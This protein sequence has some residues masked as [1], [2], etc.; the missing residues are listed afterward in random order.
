MA[1]QKKDTTKTTAPVNEVKI[2]KATLDFL[3]ESNKM[4]Q[5]QMKKI[6]EKETPIVSK[7]VYKW[8]RQYRYKLFAS[9]EG[10]KEVL[11]PI[12]SY[13]SVK[14]DPSQDWVYENQFGTATNNQN[15]VLTLQG[16]K[17]VLE[18]WETLGRA[19]YSE[20]QFP[21]F[22]EDVSGQLIK[23]D[24]AL[25]ANVE[26]PAAYIFENEYGEFRI[27]PKCIN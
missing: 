10:T 7:D 15:V 9:L 18:P 26:N 11:T 4:L 14:K 21:K 1:R 6:A 12:L 5:E 3:I 20:F 27:L 16:G 8:P 25:A 13:R 24:T 17:E 22:V 2:N 23:W 19:K